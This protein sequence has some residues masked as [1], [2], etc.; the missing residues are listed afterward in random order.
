[1]SPSESEDLQTLRSSIKEPSKKKPA[2]NNQDSCR[3]NH[4]YASNTFG[5][6]SKTE[7]YFQPSS[8][9]SDTPV[10]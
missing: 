9:Y 8:L 7:M 4:E 2:E 1:M 3:N 10:R 6:M 5:N